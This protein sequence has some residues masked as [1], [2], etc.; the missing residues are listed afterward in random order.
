MGAGERR[1]EANRKSPPSRPV[2]MPGRICGLSGV[3]MGCPVA[4]AS[5]AG[6]RNPTA[7]ASATP[8]QTARAMRTAL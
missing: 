3:A 7:G 2:T 6:A 1:R 5:K 8:L 4:A